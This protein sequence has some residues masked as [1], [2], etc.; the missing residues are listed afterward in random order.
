MSETWIVFKAQDMSMEGWERRQLFPSEALTD[1]LAEQWDYSGQLPQ[2]GDRV[3]E[4]ANLSEPGN[5]VTHSK[6]GDWVV[7]R[8]Q[9]FSS[10]DTDDRIVICYCDYQPLVSEWQELRRGAPITELLETAG[11]VS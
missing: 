3:R 11:I 4:Y 10:F 8:V 7:S 1:I 5:G 9:H 6:D 2:V